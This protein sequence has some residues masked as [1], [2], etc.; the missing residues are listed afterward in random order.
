MKFIEI[1]RSRYSCRNYKTDMVEDD[2]LNLVLE[3]ARIAPS[4]VNYQPWHFIVIKNK[5]NK[6]KIYESYHRD[7][8]KTAPVLII[9]CGDHTK[10]WKRSDGKDHLDIDLSIAVDHMTLQAVELGLAT[11]WV[12]NFNLKILKDNFK[13]PETIEPVVILPLGYPTEMSD[14]DRHG[15]NR[16]N[17]SEI[18][19]WEGFE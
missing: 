2:K 18:I 17:I 9:A 12:C 11:C 13:L 19:L 7:W 5:E 6:E 15:S 14:P 16:K 3:A 10:S 4:A 1:A 8:I